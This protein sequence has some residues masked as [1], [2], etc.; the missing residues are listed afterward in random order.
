MPSVYQRRYSIT[1]FSLNLTL[2]RCSINILLHKQ[3]K[4]CRK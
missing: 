4:Y 1:K 2:I 3:T